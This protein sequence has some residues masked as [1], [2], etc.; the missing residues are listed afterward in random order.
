[1]DICFTNFNGK[2]YCSVTVDES[3]FNG[4]LRFGHEISLTF[5][6]DGS[7]WK[8]DSAWHCGVYEAAWNAYEEE[9]FDQ[10]FPGLLDE[11]RKGILKCESH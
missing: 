2:K 6:K 5:L 10:F 8:F 7:D 1:M 3:C 11:V 9:D 4:I